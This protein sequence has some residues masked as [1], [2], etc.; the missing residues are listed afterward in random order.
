MLFA[1]CAVIVWMLT[2]NTLTY[3]AFGYDKAAA[4]DGRRRVPEGTLLNLALLGG[5][6][7]AYLASAHFRHKTR[8]Q[9]FRRQ[10][11]QSAVIQVVLLLGAALYPIFGP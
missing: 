11:H 9:P 5:T 8:K 4:E 2:I 3:L 6:P 1:A 10:L 7:A